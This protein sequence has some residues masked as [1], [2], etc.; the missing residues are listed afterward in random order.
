MKLKLTWLLTL[1]MAFVMQFSFAQ[2]KAV[3]G[4]VT[5]ADDGLPL[6]GANVIVKGTARG[7]QTDFDGKFTINVNSG[8]I[9]V[10]S[11]VGMKDAEIKTGAG[12]TYNVALKLDNT[13]DEVVVIGNITQSK[14]KSTVAAVK[15]TAEA[16]ENRPN[17]SFIQTLNG[18]VAGLNITTNSGQPGGN[19]TVNLRG[20]TSINGDAE[21]LFI[22]DGVPIDQDNFR[23]LNPQDIASVDV[24]KDAGATAI[25]G[26]RG[27]N[28]VIVITTRTGNFGEGLKV[29]YNG[30]VAYSSLQGNDYNVMSSQQLLRYER[31]R[32]QG[33][34]AGNSTS[35]FNP[36]NGTPLT[37]AQIDAAPNFRWDEF[38]FRTGVTQ[39]HTVSLSS[40]SEKATQ[41]TSFGFQDTEGILQ[42]SGLKR[43]NIRNNVTGRSAD[44]K[45]S[46]GTNITMNYSKSA[47]PNNIGGNGINRNFIIGAFEGVPYITG[48]DYTDGAAL[49][50]PLSFT[51]TPLFLTDLLNT[52]TIEDEEIKIVA[53]ANFSYQ[54]TDWLTANLTLGGDYENEIFLRAEAPDSF[55]A[56]L[57]GGAENPT[58]GFQQQTTTRQLIF[59]SISSLNASKTFGKHTVGAGLYAEYNKNHFRQFG[60]F[61]NG[62]NG[63]TF[64]PGD[65]SGLVAQANGLFNDEAN[66]QILNTGLFSV[67]G[68]V[69]YDFDS[70]YGLS[71]SLRR[72]AS[73]RFIND[74][75]WGTFWSVA[76]RWNISNEAFMED[77]VFNTLKLRGSYGITGNQFVGGTLFGLPDNYLDLFSSGGGYGNLNSFNLAQ[78]GV[79]DTRWEEVEQAN[80]GL[81]F[82]VFNNRL[83]G[84]FD[85][86]EKKTINLFQDSPT[87]AVVGVTQLR[88]NTGDLFNRGFDI[89][90][91]YDI[92]RSNEPGGFN[93]TA[94][95]VANYNKTEIQNLPN[96]EGEIIQGGAFSVG[97]G[98]NGGELF[99]Y[100]GL[101]YAGVNPANGELLYLDINGDV[102][103]SPNQ[104]SDRVW[105]DKTPLPDWT[106]SFKLDVEFKNFYLNQQWAFATG[107]YRVDTDYA[108]LTDQDD[109]GQFNLSADVLRE[110]TQPGDV[111]DIPSPTAANRNSFASDRFLRNADFLRLRFITFGYNFTNEALEN[112]PFKKVNLYVSGEN[113][114]TFTE[115]IGNDPETR[116]V[117]TAAGTTTGRGYPT[118]RTFSFGVNI[119]F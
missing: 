12:S 82:G 45:F 86:Y 103:E 47:E 33:A 94:G 118:P 40:G 70:R 111:T 89:G 119:G 80:I 22:M 101:R 108:S 36:G 58:S 11:Y 39:S 106:G 87:S 35:V 65:G 100:F 5:T 17:P 109:V 90:I 69:D 107:I 3:T 91:D 84:S 8:D 81:D 13:L 19:S 23:S 15:L 71:A 29:N 78:I 52:F 10:I 85:V 28:G 59:N 37:D 14:E 68:T 112:T 93:L 105:L 77:S 21:P 27:A 61:A 62:L 30:F 117:N 83:R 34:G 98:Q 57:F 50:S 20:V 25:Y 7:A 63:S 66:A 51:N 72:D 46:Y 95:V 31:D 44:D 43:F 88:V 1:F 54:L 16:I 42:N 6:P 4:T 113:L 79:R 26:N 24:L 96:P 38:F 55:N 53:S 41:F 97:L 56:L 99:E 49:L 32:G 67:F 110:W 73:S 48:D 76:G 102:T 75:Q 114:I 104:D 74:F 116:S 64:S 60:Y 9:L 115:W 2:E 18:Q 92:F